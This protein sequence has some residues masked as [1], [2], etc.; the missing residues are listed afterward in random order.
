MHMTFALLKI[1]ETMPQQAR[2]QLETAG[3]KSDNP[4]LLW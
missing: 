3:D 1:E 2:E 4:T